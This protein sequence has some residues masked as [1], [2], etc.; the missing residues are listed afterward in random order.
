ME[1]QAVQ[2]QVARKG[3]VIGVFSL[4]GLVEQLDT[5]R[6][7]PEDHY[8]TEGMGDWQ[9]LSQLS[10]ELQRIR[11]ELTEARQREQ[12]AA[13]ARLSA[14]KEAAQAR[15]NAEDDARRELIRQQDAAAAAN[16]A[17][18][19]AP[20]AWKCHTCS[21]VFSRIGTKQSFRIAA[22][23]GR[24]IGLT[25]I[26]AVLLAGVTSV[27]EP[28]A[29]FLLILVSA[30]LVLAAI[31]SVIAFGVETG[32]QQFY[33]HQPRCPHCSSPYCS[34]VAAEI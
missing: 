8:W 29:G 32:L 7:T 26:A 14:E 23:I 5:G 17:A 30:I 12:K 13:E 33:S 19:L 21:Q 31:G 1:P 4:Q 9:P 2:Y 15:K 6:L 24:A 16:K 34:K 18:Q 3:Q 10:S 20:Q 25:V 28:I 22:G 11:V 27:R